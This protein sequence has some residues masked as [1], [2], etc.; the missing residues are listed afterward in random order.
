MIGAAGATARADLTIAGLKGISHEAGTYARNLVSLAPALPI[1]I[2]TSGET[3]VVSGLLSDQAATL[4]LPEP[5]AW[6]DGDFGAQS[7][8][9]RTGSAATSG[10]SELR[11]YDIA[12]D[13]Q[14]GL[15]RAPV[16]ND[17]A[18]QSTF[19]LPGSFDAVDASRLAQEISQRSSSDGDRL[20][21]R[22]SAIDDALLPGRIVRLP[23]EPG[24]WRIESWE[25]RE[26]GIELELAR[27]L[28]PATAEGLSE[29]GT[30]WTPLDRLPGEQ[31]LRA[32]E[33]P[34]DG[35]GPSSQRQVFAAVGAAD[36]RWSGAQLYAEQG[37]ELVPLQ[38]YADR[39][40]ISGQLAEALGA[41][42]ALM[43]EAGSSVAVQLSDTAQDLQPVSNAQLAQGA[44]RAL[45]G[46]EIVQFR[47]VEP[48]GG[49]AY[50]L[51]GL[52]RGRGAT[53][54]EAQS[55]HASGTSFTLLDQRIVAID[56]TA[57]GAFETLTA[58]SA[59]S[60]APVTAT[61]ENA[62]IAKRPLAPVHAKAVWQSDGGVDLSWIRR[63]R[64]AWSWP[65]QVEV[66][67]VEEAEL[68]EIGIG[69]VI[70]PIAS[71]TAA[72]P[73]L[74]LTAIALNTVSA[75]PATPIWVRQ[76][77]DHARSAATLLTLTP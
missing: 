60:D 66:P 15:Q 22:I 63:A 67:L 3:P 38:S 4:S 40:A 37:A 57:V 54:A 58:I 23:D 6:P 44:N 46:Q 53:E 21:Y 48:L 43:F 30:P 50:R 11:Y 25:W 75:D 5:I 9:G 72:S 32:F 62:G 69:P 7:G 71:F 65:S 47:D 12:R 55:G 49:G 73:A 70:A 42:P 61:I 41:S 1:V 31:F 2:D 64:G 14:P 8:S 10:I 17:F 74:S 18:S 19:E 16:A 20:V 52:L 51:S 59:D 34:W 13:Y 26:G 39:R 45:I 28:L 36:G 56:E 77:G 27:H 29:A 24:L 76:V 33:L 35:T 68:Y